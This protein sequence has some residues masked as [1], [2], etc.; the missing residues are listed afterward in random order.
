MLD[1]D[2]LATAFLLVEPT[3]PGGPGWAGKR[4]SPDGTRVKRR[5]GAPA[6]LERAGN[7]WR[8]RTGRPKPGCLTERQ[9]RRLMA[10]VIRAA[11]AEAG[12]RRARMNGTSSG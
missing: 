12:E 11:E 8:P 9:A 2:P 6:L 1:P 5:L 3:R 4:R 10:T 7:G